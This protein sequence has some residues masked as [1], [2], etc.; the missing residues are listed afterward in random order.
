MSEILDMLFCFGMWVIII[1]FV[2][3]AVQLIQ[4]REL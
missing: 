3:V 4:H 1:V 2:Y